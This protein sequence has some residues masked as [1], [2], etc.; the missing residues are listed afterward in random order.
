MVSR[1]AVVLICS[2]ILSLAPG[3]AQPLAGNE[4]LVELERI[5]PGDDPPG[6]YAFAGDAGWRC[7]VTMGRMPR[8]DPEHKAVAYQI[9]WETWLLHAGDGARTCIDRMA[10]LSTPPLCAGAPVEPAIAW[11]PDGRAILRW[12]EAPVIPAKPD[13]IAQT[14][15][16]VGVAPY[17]LPVSPAALG[18]PLVRV[19][20][21]SVGRI[22]ISPDGNKVCYDAVDYGNAH[23]ATLEQL[24]IMEAGERAG[25][26]LEL[27]PLRGCRLASPRWSPDGRYLAMDVVDGDYRGKSAVWLVDGEQVW[28]IDPEGQATSNVLE[29]S[30]GGDKM[31]VR[32]ATAQGM[33]V[34]VWRVPDAG[35]PSL[36]S[37]LAGR[38]YIHWACWSPDGAQVAGL[39][40]SRRLLD[41]DYTAEVVIW[42]ADGLTTTTMV[43]CPQGLRAR[44]LDW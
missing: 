7:V 31:L 11:Y 9:G 29:W 35:D 28:I 24:C 17:V 20:S 4:L 6:V 26:P 36:V 44:S 41:Q 3:A 42:S 21:T 16:W 22:A 32:R 43:R 18:G 40:G 27:A 14:A 25:K 8:W 12:S 38:S 39:T 34:D 37:R 10:Y 15:G 19:A 5:G 33:T 1:H 23:G 30:P 13:P 2:A